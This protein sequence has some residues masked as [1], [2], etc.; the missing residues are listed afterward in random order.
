MLLVQK[1]LASGKTLD[2]LQSEH[3]VKS[4]PTNGKIVLNYDQIEARDSDPLSQQCR[5]LVLRAGDFSIVAC[6]MFRFFNKEQEG[7]AA[8][9][10]W[11]TAVYE[12][13]MDGSCIIVYYDEEQYKWCCGTRGRCEA[14]AAAHDA[15]M[16]FATMVD[17]TVNAMWS[18]KHPCCI[19]DCA[20][21]LQEFCQKADKNKT[22][23]FELTSPLNRIVC[24][25]D[26][27]TLTLLAVRDITTLQEED[28]RDNVEVFEDFGLKTPE[29][30]EFNNVNHMIQVIRDWSPEDHEGIVVKD[31]QFN[32]IKVKNPAYVTYNHM[33]NSLST[34]LRGCVEVILVGKDDDVVAMMPD[35][36]A[37]RIRRLKPAI[38]QV[39]A[40]TQKDY[41]ELKGIEDMKTYALEAQKR[42]WPA[43]LFALKRK[44]T[45][46]LQTF[47]LGNREDVSKIPST[48]TN[49]MLAMC[50]KVDP[51][52]AK[53][54]V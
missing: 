35:V 21:N 2:D 12:N 23:V 18:R 48:A 54:E 31:A 46:D 28:P 47:A 36:I 39:L 45:P 27:F 14:D 10:D 51:D 9:I 37:N 43:A 7:V 26:E 6:P 8:T 38:Q 41:D 5:G 52:V 16:T 40:Q 13:K 24:K 32:R 20:A 44:K 34:S 30:Y 15:G 17:S 50:R 11:S 22:Y 49:T 3:G 25:Y 53:L 29:I 19:R 4:Y 1:Y 42:L 33:Q